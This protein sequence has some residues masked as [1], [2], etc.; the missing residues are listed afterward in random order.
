MDIPSSYL[1]RLLSNIL[2]LV[3]VVFVVVIV[4]LLDDDDDDDNDNGDDAS[5]MKNFFSHG[6]YNTVILS[7]RNLREKRFTTSIVRS[8]DSVSAVGYTM[9][10]EGQKRG[11]QAF[12]IVPDWYYSPFYP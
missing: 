10:P 11:R 5:L 4:V 12:M 7:C 3:V 1:T 8:G 2:L 9:Y 6:L